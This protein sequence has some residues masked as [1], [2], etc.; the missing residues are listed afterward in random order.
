MVDEP[1][2]LIGMKSK[3]TAVVGEAGPEAIV[4]SNK[5][6]FSTRSAGTSSGGGGGESSGNI[7]IIIQGQFLEASPSKWS[8]FIKEQI[9]PEIRRSTMAIPSGP[10]NRVRG[11]I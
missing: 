10:F 6:G 5:G 8:R 9:I 7:T 11:A 2:L 3:K 4:P 1:S